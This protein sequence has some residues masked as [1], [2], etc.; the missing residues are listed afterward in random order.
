MIKIYII[1]ITIETIINFAWLI[2]L[3]YNQSRFLDRS[4]L[5][6]IY[7]IYLIIKLAYILTEIF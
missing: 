5:T 4:T 6:N 3:T 7:W 2:A 1:I